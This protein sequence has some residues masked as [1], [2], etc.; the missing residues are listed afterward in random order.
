[1][2]DTPQV[3]SVQFRGAGCLEGGRQS[4]KGNRRGGGPGDRHT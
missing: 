3:Q 2:I 4:L 1:M